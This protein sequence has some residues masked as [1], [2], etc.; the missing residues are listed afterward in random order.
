MVVLSSETYK[1]RYFWK[2][3][4][5]LQIALDVHLTTIGEL[6]RPKKAQEED[7]KELEQAIGAWPL[8]SEHSGFDNSALFVAMEA[9]SEYR[10]NKVDL[11]IHHTP[12]TIYFN[13]DK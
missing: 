6:E 2:G 12:T 11:P 5:I 9:V 13:G 4:F 3:R 7:V 8:I 1:Q 10:L